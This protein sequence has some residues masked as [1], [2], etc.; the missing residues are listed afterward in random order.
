MI[1]M[2]Q[3]D[4]SKIPRKLLKKELDRERIKKMH[5]ILIVAASGHEIDIYKLRA[6]YHNYRPKF[7]RKLIGDSLY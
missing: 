3:G 4:S 2:L 7:R 1:V 5:I 6:F